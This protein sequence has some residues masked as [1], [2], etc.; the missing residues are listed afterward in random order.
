MSVS[1]V[2]IIRCDAGCGVQFVSDEPLTVPKVRQRAIHQGWHSRMRTRDICP[3]CW[4]KGE[5]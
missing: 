3:W 2:R 4:E 1:V 5:R